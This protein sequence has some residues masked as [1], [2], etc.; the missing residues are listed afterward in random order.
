MEIVDIVKAGG[1]VIGLTE[2]IG[3][4]VPETARDTVLPLLA[5]IFGVVMTTV[6]KILAGDAATA[7]DVMMGIV[8]GGTTTGLYSVTARRLS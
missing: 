2:V 4:F 7:E 8:I 1:A 6:P 3:K 5:L